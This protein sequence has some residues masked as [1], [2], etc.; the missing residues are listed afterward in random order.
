MATLVP[1]AAT[2]ALQIMQF[3]R[4]T[5]GRAFIPPSMETWLEH[6]ACYCT[7]GNLWR[8]EW[9]G[10]TLAQL[11]QSSRRSHRNLSNLGFWKHEL[12]STHWHNLPV[13]SD[14]RGRKLYLVTISSWSHMPTRVWLIM[15]LVF[16]LYL[17]MVCLFCTRYALSCKQS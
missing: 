15:F 9:P 11:L 4:N 3:C 8:R 14:K 17:S 16:L 5:P 1:F 6:D 10:W 7:A 13:L 2:V 12:G